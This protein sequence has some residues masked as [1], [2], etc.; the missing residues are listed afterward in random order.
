MNKLLLKTTDALIID[1]L[2]NCTNLMSIAIQHCYIHDTHMV[3]IVEAISGHHALRDLQLNSNYIGVRGC[4]A[5][6]TLLQ[7][8]SFNLRS[9]D[10]S[11]NLLSVVDTSVSLQSQVHV[12]F[13]NVEEIFIKSLCDKSSINSTYLSNHAIT[14]LIL[15]DF[16]DPTIYRHTLTSLLRMNMG[17][18]KSHVAIRKIL[19]NHS[20][21]LADMNPFFADWIFDDEQSLK[22]LPHVI[23]W[24]NEAAEA[25]LPLYSPT[26]KISKQYSNIKRKKLSAIYQ[27]AR[28]MPLMFVTNIDVIYIVQKDQSQTMRIGQTDT[29][30]KR[31]KMNRV[32]LDKCCVIQ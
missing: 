21:I 3:Q 4:Q 18:N 16:D 28:A 22:A 2:R 24:L 17:R 13:S 27:F 30:T 9:L 5:I 11:E 7:E 20:N 6:S 32:A 10:L 26:G 14:N 1:T 8:P 19:E 12:P 29:D 25:L 31:E 23:N 15:P